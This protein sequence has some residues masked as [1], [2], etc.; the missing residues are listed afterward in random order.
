MRNPA[1]RDRRAVNEVAGRLLANEPAAKT[2]RLSDSDLMR[3]SDELQT[4]VQGIADERAHG[5]AGCGP[6]LGQI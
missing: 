1:F 4:A 3:L 5:R 6:D 2:S